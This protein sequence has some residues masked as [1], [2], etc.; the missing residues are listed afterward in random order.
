MRTLD[1]D[2]VAAVLPGYEIGAELGR[3]GFGTV[4]AAQHRLIGRNVAVKAFLDLSP[5]ADPPGGPGASA[6]TG[7]S[8]SLRSRFL[9]EARVLA[10]LDHPH[11]VRVFDYVE[12][13]G[14]CLLVME[15][16]TGGTLRARAATGLPPRATCAI[17]LAAAA[18]LDAAHGHGVLH[19]DVK[20]DNLLF[21]ADGVPR[22]TDFGIAK[23][24]ETAAASTTGMVGTPRYMAP[25]Q[26]TGAPLGPAADLYSLGVVLY[27]LLAG[28]PVFPRGLPLPALLHHHL[29]VPPSPLPEVPPPL[30]AVV[31]TVLAKDPALRPA[32]AG[33][34]ARGLAAAATAVFG[35][36]WLTGAGIPVKLPDDVLGAAGHRLGDPLPGPV[37]GHRSTSG[38]GPGPASGRGPGSVPSPS[39]SPGSGSGGPGPRP[40]P[41]SAPVAVPAPARGRG[42]PRAGALAAAAVAATA[43]C[44]GV[45]TIGLM[46]ALRGTGHDGAAVAG[47]GRAD[48][49]RSAP[50]A[51]PAYSGPG[52]T[53]PGQDYLSR[54]AL[55]RDGSLYVTA[56]RKEVGEIL[57][58]HPDGTVSQL[59]GAAARNTTGGAAGGRAPAVPAEGVPAADLALRGPHGIAVGPDDTVYVADNFGGRVYRITP[60]GR[61]FVVAGTGSDDEGFTGDDGL[62]ARAALTPLGLALAPDGSVY[63]GDG[64]RIRRVTPDGKISTVAGS[65]DRSGTSGDGG[66]A[67]DALLS[68]TNGL[69]V[70]PDGTLYVAD[71]QAHTV[72]RIAPDGTIS[73]VA[74]IPGKAG[75]DGDGGP[76]AQATLRS[77]QATALGADGTLYISDGTN[78]VRRVGPDGIITTVAG[79]GGT[80]GDPDGALATGADLEDPAGLVS[81]P[82]GALYVVLLRGATLVRVDPADRIVRTMLSP[83]AG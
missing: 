79:S 70:A 14:L 9:A 50:P 16:L 75:Y 22:V 11:I 56:R 36:G 1:L 46:I 61:A 81:D 3:G 45:L 60:E 18:A 38:T 35:P 24:V 43:L 30:A 29:S 2:H 27:E 72:R 73:H 52:L 32:T 82:T 49:A 57:R 62:A 54:V 6:G 37:A 20:P 15:Q 34:F 7:E 55:G 68:D 77:P 78:H 71:F 41:A 39:P 28:R 25:E 40:A 44:V 83:A 64:P 4:L 33:D 47:P 80:D 76:A 58:L 67:R 69:T 23:I 17:A 51:R 19:R 59:V 42:R 65:R 48:A 10:G 74:G 13:D 5:E 12:R 31:L 26:I 66:P 63:I 21:T 8:Q 53:I